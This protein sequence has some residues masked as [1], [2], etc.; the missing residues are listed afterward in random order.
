MDDKNL[1][2]KY[3]HLE[4]D[5]RKQLGISWAEYV[6]CD[7]I[8]YLSR[9]RW[10]SKKLK[11]IT[12]DMGL[13]KHGV[14]KMLKRLEAKELIEKSDRGYRTLQG[15]HVTKLHVSNNQGKQSYTNVKQSYT[16]H[17]TKLHDN[18]EQNNSK[19][20]ID[21]KPEKIGLGQGYKKAQEI[22]ASLKQRLSI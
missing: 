20:N 18:R 2:P 17:V 1:T 16:S 3:A 22:R 4:Y 5:T 13:T 10:C 15:Y 11:D 9:N 21:S 14:M 19:I 6:L 8:Y 12:S 7:M